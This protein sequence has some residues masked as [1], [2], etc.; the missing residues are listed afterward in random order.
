MAIP[1]KPHLMPRP[2]FRHSHIT[3]EPV[4]A[5]TMNRNMQKITTC[6]FSL[7]PICT[8]DFCLCNEEPCIIRGEPKRAPNTRKTGSGVYIYILFVHDLAWQRLN[9]HAQTPHGRPYRDRYRSSSTQ[10]EGQIHGIVAVQC[11]SS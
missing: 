3:F 2:L 9:A 11:G 10:I 4:C 6:M 8:I 7:K 1:S 5:P